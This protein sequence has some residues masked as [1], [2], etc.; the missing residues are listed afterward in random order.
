MELDLQ[1]PRV[2][3]TFAQASSSRLEHLETSLAAA[4]EEVRTLKVAAA[5]VRT[6]AETAESE[7]NLLRQANTSLRESNEH[8]EERLREVSAAA[9]C[10]A[11]HVSSG[12]QVQEQQRAKMGAMQEE[13]RELSGAVAHLA[14]QPP[15]PIDPAHVAEALMPQA[16]EAVREEITQQFEKAVQE[17]QQGLQN[18]SRDTLDR[19]ASKMDVTAEYA[20]ILMKVLKGFKESAD[21]TLRP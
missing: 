14:G 13:I 5:A 2:L 11:C 4:K 6:R 8:L 16:R 21:R 17:L 9:L 1:S 10:H 18:N 12:A 20:D 19:L 15:P 3:A 7:N